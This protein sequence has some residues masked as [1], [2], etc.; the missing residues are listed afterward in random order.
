MDTDPLLE[1]SDLKDFNFNFPI[2]K[3]NIE[4]HWC[5]AFFHNLDV[6]VYKKKKKQEENEK[7]HKNKRLSRCFSFLLFLHRKVQQ[8]LQPHQN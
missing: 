1:R 6:I 2:D 8:N 3:R 4:C 7:E 5:S